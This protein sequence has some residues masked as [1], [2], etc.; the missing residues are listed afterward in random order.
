MRGSSSRSLILRPPDRKLCSSS[1]RH[2]CVSFLSLG[3][4]ILQ[5]GVQE[6]QDILPFNFFGF[7]EFLLAITTDCM[8]CQCLDVHGQNISMNILHKYERGKDQGNSNVGK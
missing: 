4:Q 5:S 3:E 7:T 6:G 1:L 2:S 8:S